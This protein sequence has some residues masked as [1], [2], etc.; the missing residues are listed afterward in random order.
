MKQKNTKKNMTYKYELSKAKKK[1]IVLNFY[2]GKPYMHINDDA[3]FKGVTLTL[4]EAKKLF[5]YKNKVLE[6]MVTLEK[7][8]SDRESFSSE[9]S[10]ALSS[11]ESD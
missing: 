6:K 7:G 10:C 1:K 8:S 2:K 3:K 11:F 4:K 9:E 5:K